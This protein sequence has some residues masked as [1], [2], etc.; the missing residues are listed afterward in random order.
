M[1]GCPYHAH[2]L[3]LT[4]P[5]NFQKTYIDILSLNNLPIVILPNNPPSKEIIDNLTVQVDTPLPSQQQ[6]TK[7]QS[8]EEDLQL[9]SDSDPEVEEEGESDDN[10]G[11]NYSQTHQPPP[12]PSHN[13]TSKPHNSP[14]VTTDT[15]KKNKSG[16]RP[17]ID[18]PPTSTTSTERAP[19]PSLPI[20]S[21]RNPR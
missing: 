19:A 2:T 11:T 7:P 5:D 10:T 12:K 9:S 16:T 6:A 17:K 3:N 1:M 14:N 8:L 21:R 13:R 15:D 20:R 18:R 4:A